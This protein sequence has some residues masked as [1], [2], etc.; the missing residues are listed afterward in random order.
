MRLVGAIAAD[1][2]PIT[3]ECAN[4]VIAAVARGSVLA[5]MGSEPS[6]DL[7]V[8]DLGG[9]VLLPA[10]VEPHAHI[11]KA[12]TADLQLNPTGDLAGA[13]SVS[14]AAFSVVR[15][16]EIAARARRALRAYL[17]KGCLSVRSH[18]AVGMVAGLRSMEGT[19][20]AAREFAH[21]MDI[22]IVAHVQPPIT[23]NVGREN[24][25]LL[26]E[27]IA[28]G[29]THVGGTPYR[30]EDPIAET[31]ACLEEAGAAEMGVDLH[32]DE[33]LD[34][35]T[36]TVCD[37][38]RSVK[39][40]GLPYGVTA[41]HCVSLG[42]QDAASQ[43]EIANLLAES[44]VAVVCL[45]QTN[46]Y[47]QAREHGTSKPRGLTA[48]EALYGAGVHVAAGGD[49]LQDAFNPMGRADPLEAASLLVTAGHLIPA[50]AFAAVTDTARTVLGLTPLTYE[51]GQP[52]DFVAVRGS[53]LREAIAEA[54]AR[55][56]VIR[57][58]SVLMTTSGSP[59][60]PQP[61]RWE[62]AGV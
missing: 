31:R 28:M 53:S 57:R 12:Y 21:V 8:L 39:E 56:L 26:R 16:E 41:S 42:V 11:D 25:A 18:V 46:L 10:L 60:E 59:A 49:N 19:V 43:R 47:L 34:A 3:V 30:A 20:E 62:V 55:R 2:L 61:D 9:M 23:G 17:E 50:R 44:G 58:G 37:L 32:T 48:L 5:P 40:C 13:I 29:A 4:G 33:T 45:P 27:A 24:L 1:G 22:Q 54:D 52:A 7:K 35:S 36:L 14:M 15:A 6:A 38:A 51:V